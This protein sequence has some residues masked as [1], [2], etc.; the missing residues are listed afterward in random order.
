VNGKSALAEN[1]C[2]YLLHERLEQD[3]KPDIIKGNILAEI[4]PWPTFVSI[5]VENG[6]LQDYYDWSNDEITVTLT[7]NGYLVKADYPGGAHL[8]FRI[9]WV[10][11]RFADIANVY[12]KVDYDSSKG[13]SAG[14]IKLDYSQGSS[15]E[16]SLRWKGTYQG[17]E[18]IVSCRLK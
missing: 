5:A 10:N 12:L 2:C 3:T 13:L 4:V 1:V 8:E 11:N 9:G 16:K 6:Y 15:I 14:L 7:S 17:K 18:I